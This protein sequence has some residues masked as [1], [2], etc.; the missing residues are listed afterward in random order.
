MSW[1][2]CS[3]LADLIL[4]KLKKESLEEKFKFKIANPL[5]GR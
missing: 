4:P 5:N 2:S 1:P 3:L